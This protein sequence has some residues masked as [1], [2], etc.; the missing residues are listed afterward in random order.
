[1]HS[2]STTVETSGS[3]L[4]GDV[5]AVADE[6][7]SYA[8]KVVDY[9]VDFLRGLVGY[10]ASG[11][12]MEIMIKT[13]GLMLLFTVFA[14]LANFVARVIRIVCYGLAAFTGLAAVAAVLGLI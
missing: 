4:A 2:S 11:D 1:M 13:A 12:R 10:V 14:T 5:G 8:E 7:R 3:G 9:V 6:V